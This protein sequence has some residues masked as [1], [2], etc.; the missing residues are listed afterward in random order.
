MRGCASGVSCSWRAVARQGTPLRSAVLCRTCLAPT[1]ISAYSG[2]KLIAALTRRESRSS[3]GAH[4]DKDGHYRAQVQH[5]VQ[6]TVN[7]VKQQQALKHATAY[8]EQ[9]ATLCIPWTCKT[10]KE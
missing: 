7:I 5:S 1:F 3:P 8:G 2:L 9:Q 10:S 4:S 6:F